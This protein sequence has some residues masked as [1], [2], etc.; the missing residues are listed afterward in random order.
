[1]KNVLFKTGD[2]AAN[3]SGAMEADTIS[4]NGAS[5]K[6]LMSREDFHKLIEYVMV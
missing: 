4:K 5:P 6:S 1:M 2:A 3:R